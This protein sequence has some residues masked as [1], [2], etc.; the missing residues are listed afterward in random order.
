MKPWNHRVLKT[1]IV[2]VLANT[3]FMLGQLSE[4]FSG[5]TTAW[6]AVTLCL[7]TLILCLYFV[8][9]DIWT[10]DISA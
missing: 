4:R 1:V 7:L 10:Y 6:I 3:A 2:L 9:R 5:S 8:I